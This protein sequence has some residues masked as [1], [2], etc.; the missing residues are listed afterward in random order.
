MLLPTGAINGEQPS[1]ST[2]CIC[3]RL[4]FERALQPKPLAKIHNE[5]H[6]D[7]QVLYGLYH[8]GTVINRNS[9]N[10]YRFQTVKICTMGLGYH[11]YNIPVTLREYVRED[12]FLQGHQNTL[13]VD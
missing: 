3:V 11:R 4:L 6:K 13:D 9:L 1:I 8:I 12:F 10:A 5:W 7:G 2:Y